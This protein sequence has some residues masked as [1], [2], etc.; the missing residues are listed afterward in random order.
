MPYVRFAAFPAL[1]GGNSK[2]ICYL[3]TA[4][5][6]TVVVLQYTTIAF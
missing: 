2:M 1:L 6:A 3:S 4:T 5:H